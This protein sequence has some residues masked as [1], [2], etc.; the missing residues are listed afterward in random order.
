MKQETMADAHVQ[1]RRMYNLLGEI[2][3]LSQQLADAV[4]REDQIT[5]QMLL[6]MREEPIQK[7]AETK[8]LLMRQILEADPEDSERLRALLN[9][10]S[11]MMSA[12]GLLAYLKAMDTRENA[13]FAIRLN[14]KREV[15]R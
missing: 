9:G 7:L 11:A 15:K 1:T 5:V 14:R 4:N 3:D 2:I 8:E 10:G 6:G 12:W 13:S